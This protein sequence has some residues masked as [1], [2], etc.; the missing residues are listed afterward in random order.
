MS[1]NGEQHHSEAREWPTLLV[2]GD[3]LGLKTDGRT[4][5]FPGDGSTGNRQVSN[6]FN[7]L[8]YALGDTSMDRFGREGDT[9]IAAGPLTELRS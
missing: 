5:V 9:R 3:A 6:L 1:D 2:G 7:T 8:G 4:V